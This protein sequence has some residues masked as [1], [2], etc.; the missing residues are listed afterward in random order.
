ML[1]T[2]S[3]IT[4][5][6]LEASSTKMIPIG[7]VLVAMYGASIG[8]SAISGIECCTNQAIAHCVVDEDV[9][10]SDYLFLVIKS[11]KDHLIEMGKGAA[12]PNISQ[13]VL[14]HLV[15]DIPPLSVQKRVIE[16]T[17]ELLDLCNQIET[18]LVAKNILEEAIAKT[19]TRRIAA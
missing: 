2:E 17:D 3:L 14:K 15:I 9:I 13:S 18:S 6:A 12:Q 8:K 4:Q 7:A 16:R 1:T 11:L 19:L 10:T 5:K